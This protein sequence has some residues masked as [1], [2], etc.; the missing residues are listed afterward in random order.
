LKDH[1]H[2]QTV[3]P[4]VAH[5]KSVEPSNGTPM[6]KPAPRRRAHVRDNTGSTGGERETPT[7]TR[8]IQGLISPTPVPRVGDSGAAASLDAPS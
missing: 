8:G 4:T 7:S 3:G 2:I 6:M 1:F 5:A